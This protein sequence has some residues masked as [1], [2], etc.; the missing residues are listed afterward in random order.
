MKNFVQE[1]ETLTVTAPYALTSGDGCLVGQIFGVACNTALIST[2][3]EIATEGVFDL[4]KTNNLAVSQGDLLYWN[5][6]NKELTKTSSDVP[7]AECVKTATTSGT[8]TEAVDSYRPSDPTPP[9]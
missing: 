7:V 2:D 1:G 8:V 6:T 5:D 4:K 3:V 9:T